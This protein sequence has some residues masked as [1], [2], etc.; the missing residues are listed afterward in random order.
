MVEGPRVFNPIKFFPRFLYRFAR[1]EPLFRSADSIQHDRYPVISD[2]GMKEL[3]LVSPG[4]RECIFCMP[5]LSS[6]APFNDTMP[7]R[8]GQFHR[9]SKCNGGRV[10][11]SQGNNV[12]LRRLSRLNG[13]A[14]KN[15]N[16]FAP[17]NKYRAATV[18]YLRRFFSGTRVDLF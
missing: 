12:F 9:R 11:L 14:P 10:P 2:S 18:R 16:C 17:D 1:N 6:N 3:S 4:E 13:T 15:L 8:G 5:G 7:R